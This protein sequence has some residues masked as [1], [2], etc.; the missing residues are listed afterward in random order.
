MGLIGGGR[1]SGKTS[2]GPATLPPS[3]PASL[4]RGGLLAEK[5][6]GASG[7]APNTWWLGRPASRLRG[8]EGLQPREMKFCCFPPASEERT[9]K[10]RGWPPPRD[11]PGVLPPHQ[12]VSCT[13]GFMPTGSPR[14]T[15]PPLLQD[16]SSEALPLLRTLPAPHHL[17]APRLCWTDPA[18]LM[19]HL[20]ALLRWAA[21][22]HAGRGRRAGPWQ[23]SP[24]S[25]ASPQPS[26]QRGLR[27][28]VLLH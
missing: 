18:G 19:R 28:H 3:F 15:S 9:S 25:P 16:T 11:K 4:L 1:G 5:E 26:P 17:T 8:G 23:E 13:L 6:R 12:A 20:D 27:A 24:G 10:C 22:A 14:P 2:A 7:G 21:Q